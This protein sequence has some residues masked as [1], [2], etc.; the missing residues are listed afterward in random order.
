[1]NF[2]VLTTTFE[3]YQKFLL[4]NK[5]TRPSC[6]TVGH[7]AAMS[8]FKID[9][10]KAT[11]MYGDVSQGMMNCA[12]G[13][14]EIWNKL[15][16]GEFVIFEDDAILSSS[17]FEVLDKL[18]LHYNDVKE[19]VIIIMGRSKT[20]PKYLWF[21]NLKFPLRSLVETSGVI[22]G[23]KKQNFFGTVCYYGNQSAATILKDFPSNVGWKPDDWDYIASYGLKIL[24]L[25]YPIVWED[26]LSESLTHSAR[27]IQH[28]PFKIKRFIREW[29]S[30]LK[31]QF[32]R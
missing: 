23:S 31:G 22:L 19:P 27:E 29:S 11:S 21:E 28:N 15:D 8:P 17:F 12:L 30:A 14:R 26:L 9:H 16:S 25:R 2:H 4:R 20:I 3:K 13:H 10:A 7:E 24:H 1:M 32:F 6:F 18:R 5:F